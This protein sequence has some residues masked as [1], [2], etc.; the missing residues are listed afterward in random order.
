MRNPLFRDMVGSIVRE[1]TTRRTDRASVSG[2]N[3]SDTL[4]EERGDYEDGF[5][6]EDANNDDS[7]VDFPPKNVNI[8]PPTS[9]LDDHAD[10]ILDRDYGEEQP[11]PCLPDVSAKL[12]K[13]VSTWLRVTPPRDK[14]KELFKI[15]MIPGN[16]DG[17]Q[18]VRINEL[19]Y[20]VLPLKAK[21]ADQSLRG[22]N[23]FFTKGVGPLINVLDRLIALES[24]I[25]GQDNRPVVCKVEKGVLLVND[26]E[27]DIPLLR[28]WADNSVRLLCTGNSVTLMKRRTGIRNFIPQQYHHLIKASNPVTSELLGSNLDQKVNDIQKLSE[29]ARKLHVRRRGRVTIVSATTD[30]STTD[31][32]SG[33]RVVVN[34]L[35]VNHLTLA[36]IQ[37]TRVVIHRILPEPSGKEHFL[38]II[39]A[40]CLAVG[41]D[42][43]SYRS[44]L[45]TSGGGSATMLTIGD[46]SQMIHMYLKLLKVLS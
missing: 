33:V 8:L 9:V 38:E 43:I 5:D 20:Q 46:H 34:P 31:L 10:D 27:F 1:V 28:K 36:Q 29:V 16:V 19:L 41:A 7:V 13:A 30:F 6:D 45:P 17:L 15:T 42:V 25:S 2:N 22:I 40:N 37:A 39:P 24:L 21:R 18:P 32:N 14:I 4:P 3:L 35:W 26:Q 23:S 44:C 12:A 11:R